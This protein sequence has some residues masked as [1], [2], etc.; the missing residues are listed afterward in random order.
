M[1]K[2]LEIKDTTGQS[3]EAY[4]K[5]KEEGRKDCQKTRRQTLEEKRRKGNNRVCDVILSIL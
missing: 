5:E 1:D 3:E 2:E 4:K